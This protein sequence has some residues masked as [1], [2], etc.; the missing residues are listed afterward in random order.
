MAIKLNG[1]GVRGLNG[2]AIC[3]E[4]FFLASL[5]VQTVIRKSKINNKCSHT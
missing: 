1:G 5:T 4:I 3:G 2:L